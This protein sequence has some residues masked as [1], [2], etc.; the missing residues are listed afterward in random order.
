MSR[1]ELSPDKIVD[2]KS[3]EI[4][5]WLRM[6]ARIMC[7]SCDWYFTSKEGVKLFDKGKAIGTVFGCPACHKYNLVPYY[8]E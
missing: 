1:P 5:G 2:A 8:M 4:S 7:G 6:K 3:Y